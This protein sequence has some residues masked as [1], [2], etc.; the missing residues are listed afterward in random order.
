M[1]GHVISV[2]NKRVDSFDVTVNTTHLVMNYIEQF[3]KNNFSIDKDVVA[4]CFLY[5]DKNR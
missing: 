3:I 4:D 2:V 5:Y 1:L